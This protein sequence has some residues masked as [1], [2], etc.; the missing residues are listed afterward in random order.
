MSTARAT[1]LVVLPRTL[2]T[3]AEAVG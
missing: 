2:L 1:A 3:L